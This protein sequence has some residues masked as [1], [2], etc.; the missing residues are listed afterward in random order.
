MLACF[1]PIRVPN[2][3]TITEDFRFLL[4]NRISCPSLLNDVQCK[5]FLVNSKLWYPFN[6]GLQI[7]N[8]YQLKNIW[9]IGLKVNFSSFGKIIFFFKC[10]L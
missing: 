4:L 3:E 7:S 8:I 2:N 10:F 5:K 9:S 1:N 6:N